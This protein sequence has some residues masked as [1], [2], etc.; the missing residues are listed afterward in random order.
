VDQKEGLPAK[1]QKSPYHPAVIPGTSWHPRGASLKLMMLVIK[2]L[3]ARKGLQDQA[4]G[5]FYSQA[6]RLT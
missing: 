3:V 4:L 6:G 1:F 5:S 2:T